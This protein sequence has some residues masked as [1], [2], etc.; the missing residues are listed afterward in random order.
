MRLEVS[1]MAGQ[2]TLFLGAL[3]KGR[4]YVAQEQ[5]RAAWHRRASHRK[6]PAW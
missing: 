5:Q 3:H 2:R 6:E 4:T 1:V